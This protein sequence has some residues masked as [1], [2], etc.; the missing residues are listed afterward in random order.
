MPGTLGMARWFMS[1]AEHQGAD[2]PFCVVVLKR[3]C[4]AGVLLSQTE[5]QRAERRRNH[6]AATHTPGRLTGGL[7]SQPALVRLDTDDPDEI[8][9][10]MIHRR[11]EL[12]QARPL[13]RCEDH[14]VAGHL[15]SR[16]RNLGLQEPN[17]R[18]TPGRPGE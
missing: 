16:Q 6:A 8:I 4:P 13:L 12:E 3:V 18:V 7:L 1:T 11:T 14:P 15:L 2:A 17:P 10:L 5:D 9:Y